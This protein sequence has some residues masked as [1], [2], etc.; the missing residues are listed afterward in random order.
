[1]GLIQISV[2]CLS[3]ISLAHATFYGSMTGYACN[4]PQIYQQ[5]Q[6]PNICGAYQQQYPQYSSYGQ[7]PGYYNSDYANYMNFVRKHKPRHH[8]HHHKHKSHHHHHAPAE[9]AIVEKPDSQETLDLEEISSDEIIQKTTQRP[10]TTSRPRTTTAA[11]W[12]DEDKWQSKFVSKNHHQ[13]DSSEEF[14]TI[15]S[16]E[17]TLRT[18]PLENSQRAH[19][20]VSQEEPVASRPVSAPS[21]AFGNS[22]P[23]GIGIGSSI[24]AGPVGVS[25]GLGIGAPGIGGLGS[26]GMGGLGGGGG[27]IFG[28]SSGLGIG[29]PGVGPIGVSSG[30]G[31]GK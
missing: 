11:T 24:G 19:S 23:G 18:R 17:I 31:I 26:P 30:L 28:I 2:L 9:S 12:D 7:Y 4:Q 3:A 20:F 5:C 14:P 13:I 16:D 1:M 22:N 10:T 8:H 29:I 6:C 15:D 21:P 25:S 27:G